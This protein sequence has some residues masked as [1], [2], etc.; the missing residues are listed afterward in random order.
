MAKKPL[1]PDA[2]HPAAVKNPVD[3]ATEIHHLRLANPKMTVLG[4]PRV[5]GRI[6]SQTIYPPIH[7]PTFV[8][9]ETGLRELTDTEK[10]YIRA[11]LQSILGRDFKRVNFPLGPNEDTNDVVITIRDKTKTLDSPHSK[12]LTAKVISHPWGRDFLK[13]TSIQE[14][15]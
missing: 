13:A 6:F 2:F 15:K 1:P 4:R 11:K 9:W 7:Q 14:K 12:R 3:E 8:I 10:K 5:H